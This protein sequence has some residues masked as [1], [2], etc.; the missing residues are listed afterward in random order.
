MSIERAHILTGWLEVVFKSRVDGRVQNDR[1]TLHVKH[2]VSNATSPE[3]TDDGN[4][5]WRPL[6]S[7]C[8]LTCH[9]AEAEFTLSPNSQGTRHANVMRR[10]LRNAAP[11]GTAKPLVASPV[12]TRFLIQP[13]MRRV[14]AQAIAALK[15]W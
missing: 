3:V 7:T 14:V 11:T 15:L 9:V 12:R 2:V 8:K 1:T 13:V 5:K 4:R 6:L 10:Q